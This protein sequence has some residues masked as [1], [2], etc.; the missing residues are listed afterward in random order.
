MQ[1]SY[2]RS[3]NSKDIEGSS[4]NTLISKAVKNKQKAQQ[5]LQRRKEIERSEA[6]AKRLEKEAQERERDGNKRG[7]VE[8]YH[9]QVVAERGQALQQQQQQGSNGRINV[10]PSE[11]RSPEPHIDEKKRRES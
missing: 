8:Q 4:T 2:F 7:W 6:E 5:E 3:L 10:P 11:N 9:R 1:R